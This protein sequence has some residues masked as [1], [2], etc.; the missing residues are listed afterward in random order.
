[1]RCYMGKGDVILVWLRYWNILVTGM[2]YSFAIIIV[3]IVGV[4][5]VLGLAI[6]LLYNSVCHMI[7]CRMILV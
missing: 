4:A 6:I 3:T 7:T 5:R 1:M 2:L